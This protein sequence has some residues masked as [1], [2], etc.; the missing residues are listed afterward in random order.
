MSANCK[1]PECTISQTG[2][3][4]LNNPPTACANLLAVDETE[5]A[6]EPRDNSDFG[7][8]VIGEQAGDKLA[9]PTSATLGVGDADRLMASKY[10]TI[11]GILGDPDSG[12][13][14]CLVSL[15]LLVAQA[16][17][18]PLVFA[19]S[20]SLLAFEQ[21]AR[22]ARRWEAGA[23]QQELTTRT[24]LS[25]DRQAGFLHLRLR[26]E[27]DGRRFDLLLPDLPG[28]WTSDLVRTADADRLK[29]LR[30]ADVIWLMVDGRALIDRVKRQG[31]IHRMQV[32]IERL[33]EKLGDLRP[34]LI[35]VP[36]RLDLGVPPNA[37]TNPIAR[38]AELCG[39]PFKVAPIASFA[40]ESG[41]AAPGE[42]VADL[43]TAS[44]PTR[45]VGAG[46]TFWPD[47]PVE[48]DRSFAQFRRST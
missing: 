28:E 34:E 15:Y 25:D 12:K 39:F 6:S 26:R 9:F 16:R 20:R 7:A 31:A 38:T 14:A 5:S 18:G 48:G 3:C 10:V 27:G 44:L 45:R 22:G 33:A 23:A 37:A 8:P 46:S 17:L 21:I 42:G 29:F 41:S 1:L 30:S 19:Q 40:D 47:R 11:V 43:V 2:V 24:L 36:S 4:L 13:T 32:L 35:L